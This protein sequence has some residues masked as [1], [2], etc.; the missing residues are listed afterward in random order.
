MG[1]SLDSRV[2]EYAYLGMMQISLNT[3]GH[4]ADPVPSYFHNVTLNYELKDAQRLPLGGRIQ[5]HKIPVGEVKDSATA[6]IQRIAMALPA[7]IAADKKL[8]SGYGA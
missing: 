6:A 4:Q 1:K 8:L 7:L 2:V 3:T 5:I